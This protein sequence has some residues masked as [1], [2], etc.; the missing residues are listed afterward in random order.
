MALEPGGSKRE[1]SLLDGAEPTRFDPEPDDSRLSAA[2]SG[3]YFTA[4]A[5]LLAFL[6]WLALKLFQSL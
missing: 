3:F 5:V 4:F 6:L 2:D 1:S